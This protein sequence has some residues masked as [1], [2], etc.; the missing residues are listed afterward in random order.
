MKPSEIAAKMT[1]LQKILGMLIFEDNVLLII[2]T[3]ERQEG[4]DDEALKRERGK[5]VS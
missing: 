5:R 1:L 4:E 3:P 2:H